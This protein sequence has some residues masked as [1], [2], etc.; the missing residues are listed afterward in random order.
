M[1]SLL[2]TLWIIHAAS[3]ELSNPSYPLSLA[4]KNFTTQQRTMFAIQT[5]FVTH[6]LSWFQWVGKVW[7]RVNV[8]I[9]AV[10]TMAEKVM[11]ILL[12]L[13]GWNWGGVVVEGFIL[14]IFLPN[15]Y[16]DSFKIVKYMYNTNLK[17]LKTVKDEYA[18]QLTTSKLTAYN[19]KMPTNMTKLNRLKYSCY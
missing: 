15:H 3:T 4:P 14:F 19:N 9:E 5:D 2:P 12:L 17:P 13:E 11:M 18:N 16:Y 1:N 10:G 8:T 7:K 6:S